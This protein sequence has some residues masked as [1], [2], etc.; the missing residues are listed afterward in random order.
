ML[1]GHFAQNFCHQSWHLLWRQLLNPNPNPIISLTINRIGYETCVHRFQVTCS[2]PAPGIE[3]STQ[4]VLKQ[5][6]LLFILK[7]ETRTL[8]SQ[9]EK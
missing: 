8:L 5:S 6:G 1:S 2:S 7:M 3:L 9:K 4:D